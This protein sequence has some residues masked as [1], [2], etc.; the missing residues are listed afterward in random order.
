MKTLTQASY[1]V[2]SKG[3]WLYGKIGSCTLDSS[4]QY[5]H[6]VNFGQIRSIFVYEIY[7]VFKQQKNK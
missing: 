5:L 4:W 7:I 2:R 6:I 1:Y 3:S